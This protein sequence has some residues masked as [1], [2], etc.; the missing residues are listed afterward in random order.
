MSLRFGDQVA[1][2]GGLIFADQ[3]TFEDDATV[4]GAGTLAAQDA[5]AS[6]TG[7]RGA[8]DLGTPPEVFSGLAQ[9]VGSGPRIVAGTGALQAQSASASGTGLN[10]GAIF[11]SG[12]L[13]AQTASVTGVG[14][15]GIGGVGVLVAQPAT[16]VGLGTLG[17][18]VFG[19][20]ILVAQ[21]ATISGVG[22][23]SI[24]GAGTLM[25]QDASAYGLGTVI[26][27]AVDYVC[28]LKPNPIML[29]MLSINTSY[30]L[31]FNNPRNIPRSMTVGWDDLV[32]KFSGVEP[33]TEVA[34]RFSNDK[35]F[36]EDQD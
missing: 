2:T 7:I 27:I 16:V 35:E 11:G 17:G 19:S 9:V 23:R 4:T 30:S 3:T 28:Y 21:E 12:V 32:T 29:E 33:D 24:V 36:V 25:S 10:Y 13:L 15:P 1:A 14:L 34:Y 31:Q 5:S 26:K 6:G 20:G 22:E 18:Q 8:Q